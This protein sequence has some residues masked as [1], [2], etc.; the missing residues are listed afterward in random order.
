MFLDYAKRIFRRQV[1]S[2]TGGEKPPDYYDEMYSASTEYCKP[3]WQSRYY[4]LWTVICDRLRSGNC[5]NILEIGCG[6][7]QFAEMLHREGRFDYLGL[8][9]SPEAIRQASQKQLEPFQF[10]TGDALESDVILN[11]SYDSVVCT[12]VLEHIELDRELVQR[13]RPG[14]RCL[15]TVPNFPYVSHVRH[16]ES[17]DQVYERYA[18]FFQNLNVWAIPGPH[19]DEIVYFIADGFRR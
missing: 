6:S 15:C 11:H 3:F 2:T 14:T 8:D 10:K 17:C 4:F 9:I 12:E 18:N 16:F 7:G 13:I 1:V 19:G 5:R